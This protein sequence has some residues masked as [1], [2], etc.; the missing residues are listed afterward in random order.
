MP[1]FIII[2]ITSFAICFV[3]TPVFI[4]LALRW[5]IVD[6]PDRKIKKHARPTPYLGGLAIAFGCLIPLA[7]YKFQSSGEGGDGLVGIIL[8][9]AVVLLAGLLD[10]VWKFR[11]I[12]KLS[13]QLG[14]AAI[15]VLNG[16]QLECFANQPLAIFFTV[17]WVVGMANAFNFI[18]IMDGL[19]AGVACIACLVFMAISLPGGDQQVLIAAVALAG[20]ALAFLRYNFHPAKIFMGDAG[21]QFIGF[22]MA[23]L[24]LDASYTQT[25]NIALFVP[26]LIL[27][28][29]IF[30]TVLV[31]VLRTM[32]G[33]P[34]FMGSEDHFA[35]R[36]KRRGLT[37]PQVVLSL[38]AV[39]AIL[40]A[41]AVLITKSTVEGA[42]FVYACLGM[43]L[44]VVGFLL[45]DGPGPGG[46]VKG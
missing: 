19:A 44:L 28:V 34:F 5:N 21:S 3:I 23:A 33:V 37:V 1:A 25:N 31:V 6:L 22:F 9:S 4:R 18:D 35:L 20:A 14:A 29:P 36:L 26:V 30:D 15:L 27:G 17:L 24:A 13:A 45:A 42:M 39:S 8:G 38:Y 10:D 16:V 12:V 40:G 32:R 2:F 41:C 11:P 43:V 46:K 7:I